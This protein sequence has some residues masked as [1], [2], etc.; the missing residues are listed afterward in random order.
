MPDTYQPQARAG[1]AFDKQMD[2]ALVKANVMSRQA[3]W[4]KWGEAHV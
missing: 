4:K 1:S 3:F 2:W